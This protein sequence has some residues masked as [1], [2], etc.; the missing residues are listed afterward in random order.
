MDDWLPQYE[1]ISITI[2]HD[3]SYINCDFYKIRYKRLFQTNDSW[4]EVGEV[5]KLVR[6]RKHWKLAFCHLMGMLRNPNIRLKNLTIQFL[7]FQHTEHFNDILAL[8]SGIQA[9]VESLK[10]HAPS[11]SYLDLKAL[12][13][14]QYFKPVILRELCIDFPIREI[15]LNS[16]STIMHEVTQL[17]QFKVCRMF[18]VN[19]WNTK[20]NFIKWFTVCP[21]TTV[22]VKYGLTTH[23]AVIAVK[24]LAKSNDIQCLYLKT[25]DQYE[26]E[27]EGI[28]NQLSD[29]FKEVENRPN[30]RHRRNA[31]PERTFEVEVTRRVIRIELIKYL[32]YALKK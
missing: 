21:R 4:I 8:W 11:G 24:H 9:H 10:L 12:F 15:D 1:T 22:F 18:D 29:A 19:T 32:N 28:L 26:F 31:I 30:V 14:L 20:G 17:E 25:A 6:K 5:S 27:P 16:P 2:S 23:Q 3:H 7:T 13:I